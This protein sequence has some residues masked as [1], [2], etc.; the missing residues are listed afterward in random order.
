M[1]CRNRFR[2]PETAQSP[3]GLRISYGKTISEPLEISFDACNLLSVQSTKHRIGTVRFTIARVIGATLSSIFFLV[4]AACVTGQMTD[5]LTYHNDNART[6]QALHEEILTPANVNTNHFGKLWI[7]PA[8]GKVD[9]QPLYVAGISVPGKGTR[10][11]LVVVTEHDSV[12][13]YDADSTNILWRVSLLGTNETTSD[14]HGCGQVTP[15]IGI[16]DTPVVDRQL[17]A[18]G[19]IF[20]VAMSKS[21]TSTYFH[22]LHALDLAT[23]ADRVPAVTVTATYPGTGDNNSGGNVIFD[24]ARYK[25]RP[26]LLLLNGLIYTAWSSHCDARPYTGWIM[27]YNEQTLAQTSVLNVTPNGNE[28]AIWM[29]GDGLAADASANI[30]F[31]DANGFF[32]STFTASGFP[33]S[34]NY[35]NAFIKLST[36]GNT[37]TVADYFNMSNAG[38][39]NSTD[40]DLGSG[41]EMLLPDMLDAQSNTRQLAVGAGK[42]AI[43]YLVDRTNMGKFSPSTNAIYQQVNGVLGGRVFST[44][45][46]FNGTLYYG[47]END[48]IKA[49]PFQNARLTAVSS[50]TPGAF[51][52]PGATP[53][54]SANG[55]ANG[56]V[57]ATE[58]N[59]TAVLHAYNAAN[60]ANEL[61]NS[62]QATGGRDN[63]GAG[64]KFITPTIASA[65]VYVGTTTGV[66]VFGLLDQSMLT[67]L[68]VW[69]ANHFGNPS[70]VGAGA[71]VASPAGDGVANLIKYALGLDPQTPAVNSQLPSGSIQPDG[72]QRYLTLTANRVALAPDVTYA[73]EVSGDLQNW[74]SGPP[75]TV[76][77]SNSATQLT[78]R[79]NVPF[80]SAP[81]RFI[82]LRIS[83][84]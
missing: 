81:M 77:L 67:P 66:G 32:D 28:G 53:S 43:I 69:R 40:E 79:D 70:N 38:T 21:G 13:A 11:V 7:L 34:N 1:T 29:A 16:T 64:N 49:I 57:W 24:P 39:E 22:R 80:G 19:T 51:A 75:F 45:A 82:H 71:D 58:N 46:Y 15:E 8:D 76:T 60:L 25:E 61:Y 48:H 44:P 63:F 68:Q 27:A 3:G 73:V 74:S 35:G 36:T 14:D 54:V 31:L 6:G 72:S 55:T 41:G 23:G 37:L 42:D 12:Y 9:A 33:I 65:R 17:G 2:K 52:F 30:Y 59:G 83:D 20:L 47:A 62:S 10:N 18:N 78:V 5:V 50:Q 56:I 26:G 84:P 4:T